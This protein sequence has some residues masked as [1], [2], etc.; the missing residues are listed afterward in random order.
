MT[1]TTTSVVKV[2]D[3]CRMQEFVTTNLSIVPLVFNSQTNQPSRQVDLC[4]HCRIFLDTIV[5]NYLAGGR[6]F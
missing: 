4:I 3:R 2:C 6:G 5:T 1:I